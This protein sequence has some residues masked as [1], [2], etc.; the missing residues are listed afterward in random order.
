MEIENTNTN[1]KIPVTI[2]TGFLGAGKTTF[3][4]YL[5]KEQHGKRIAVIQNEFGEDVEL[6]EEMLIYG[7]DGNRE[8]IT[9][10]PMKNGCICCAVKDD[11]LLTVESLIQVKDKFDYIFIECSG[12]AEPG[13]VAS[14]FWVDDE[15][16]SD[17]YLDAMITLVDAKHFL[18]HLDEVKPETVINEAQQQVAFA[19]R[20]ILNKKDLV[21]SQELE[22]LQSRIKQINPLAPIFVT[23][24]SRVDLD[25]ILNIRAFDFQKALEIDPHLLFSDHQHHFH[26]SSIRTICLTIP[27]SILLSEFNSWLGTLLWERNSSMKIFRC[28]GII[29]L[30]DEKLKYL[31]QGVHTLFDVQPSLIEWKPNETKE[32]RLVFIGRN[33]NEEE[34]LQS[35]KQ[36]IKILN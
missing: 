25:Q 32:N 21:S 26:D 7:K 11:L 4:N 14:V 24:R 28:K 8:P 22:N 23:E 17:V 27:G 6:T 30:V 29:C 2:L 12:L 31:L 18:L 16:E 15:L 5:L 3:L 36:N 34:L 33:L 20:I 19:D 1:K 9:A 13:A 10:I 35:F